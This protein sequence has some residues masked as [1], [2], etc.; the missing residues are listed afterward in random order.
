MQHGKESR[1]RTLFNLFFELN[2]DSHVQYFTLE[3]QQHTEGISMVNL[4]VDGL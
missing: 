2:V 3:A 1:I 4:L